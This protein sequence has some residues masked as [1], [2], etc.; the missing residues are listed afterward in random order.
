L[1]DALKGADSSALDD[2]DKIS[3]FISQLR[4]GDLSNKK[5]SEFR[6]KRLTYEHQSSTNVSPLESPQLKQQQAM[7]IKDASK[8]KRT[9]IFSSSEIGVRQD[10][11][12]PFPPFLVGTFSCHGN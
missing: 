3:L 4:N 10:K 1:I 2:Q 8:P 9:T 5:P 12:A 7:S 11:A 6:K